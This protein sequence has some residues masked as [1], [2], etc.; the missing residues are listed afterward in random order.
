MND[1]NVSRSSRKLISGASI[2]CPR[3]AS[4]FAFC[5]GVSRLGNPTTN[6]Q[7]SE[8]FGQFLAT[9]QCLQLTISDKSYFGCRLRCRQ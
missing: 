3:I 8:L 2:S 6:Q 5:R 9:L 7:S 1:I 4:D